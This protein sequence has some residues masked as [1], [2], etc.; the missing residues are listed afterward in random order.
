MRLSYGFLINVCAEYSHYSV[1][2][3]LVHLGAR[4]LNLIPGPHRRLLRLII[5]CL[6]EVLQHFADPMSLEKYSYLALHAASHVAEQ[7]CYCT[8]VAL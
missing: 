5:T 2:L 7:A 8:E 1:H 4:L 3:I 6:L